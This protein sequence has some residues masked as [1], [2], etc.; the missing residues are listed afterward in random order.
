MTTDHLD[1]ET[2]AELRAELE[3]DRAEIV[4]KSKRA[5]DE[6]REEPERGGQDSVDESTEEQGTATMLRQKDREKKYLTKVNQA[7]E[8]LDEGTYGTCMQ[9]AEPIPE[10]R[11][12]ARPAAVLCIDC[13]EERERNENQEKK[14]PGLM[15]DF[16]M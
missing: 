11:L 10:E 7:L 1:D 5:L 12:R 6:M 8:R 15:D 2:L 14:R 13:K 16:S 3:R 9:C 4:D